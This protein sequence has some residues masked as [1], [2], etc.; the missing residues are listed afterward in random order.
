VSN[1]QLELPLVHP[2]PLLVH[3]SLDI[4]IM[5]MEIHVLNVQM[6]LLLAKPQLLPNVQLDI[7]YKE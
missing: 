3:V 2:L 7:S 4:S 5:L 6:E 1:V